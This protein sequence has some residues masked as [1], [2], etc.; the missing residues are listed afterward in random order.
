MPVI[1]RRNIMCAHFP[2]PKPANHA[3][4]A[5]DL[6]AANTAWIAIGGTIHVW[7]GSLVSR[8]GEL[9]EPQN[10]AAQLALASI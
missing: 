6:T 2:H 9:A 7:R 1:H 5:P 3:P 8:P 10:L 4:T